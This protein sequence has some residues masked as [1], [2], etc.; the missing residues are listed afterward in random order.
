[1]QCDI[2]RV[3]SHHF[4]DKYAIVGIHS[5]TNLVD[6]FY[7]SVYCCVETNREVGSVNVLINSTSKSNAGNIEFLAKLNG[8]TKRTVSA[9]YHETVD[10]TAFKVLVSFFATFFIKKFFTTRR[11][12]DSSATLDDIGH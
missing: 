11:F 6:R 12:Q 8:A 9:N 4:N 10:P 7:S 2:T 5:V 3:A 1:M